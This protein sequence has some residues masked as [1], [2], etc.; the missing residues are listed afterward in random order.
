MI[1]FVVNWRERLKRESRVFLVPPRP[2]IQLSRGE[3][4]EKIRKEA[5]D[6]KIPSKLPTVTN[7]NEWKIAVASALLQASAYGDK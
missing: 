2:V 4:G 3:K 6:V 5:S 7:V 1:T